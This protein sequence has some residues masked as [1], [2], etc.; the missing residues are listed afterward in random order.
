[1]GRFHPAASANIRSA[2][3]AHA[4]KCQN[5]GAH[6][7]SRPATQMAYPQVGCEVCTTG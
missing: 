5:S 4:G 3:A 6:T 1:M 2:P 7:T